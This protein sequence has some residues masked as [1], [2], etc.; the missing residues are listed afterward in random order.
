MSIFVEL[1]KHVLNSKNRTQSRTLKK[2][3]F[4]TSFISLNF[5]E[6]ATNVSIYSKDSRQCL[7]TLDG[8]YDA[9]HHLAALGRH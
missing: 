1:R 3:I 6:H 4:K 9:D 5:L 8:Q 7:R 2:T